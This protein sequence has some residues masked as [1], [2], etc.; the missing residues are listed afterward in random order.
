MYENKLGNLEYMNN[1]LETYKLSKLNQEETESL[2]RPITKMKTEG[3]IKNLP[4]PPQKK[5]KNKTRWLRS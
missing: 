4:P 2:N 3:V 5:N 1:L